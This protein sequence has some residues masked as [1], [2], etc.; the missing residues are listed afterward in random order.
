MTRPSVP[1]LLHPPNLIAKLTPNEPVKCHYTK[2]SLSN[3]LPNHLKVRLSE[4][5]DNVNNVISLVIILHK[6]CVMGNKFY[7]IKEIPTIDLFGRIP[8]ILLYAL[9]S[10]WLKHLKWY[11][12]ITSFF[13]I[14]FCTDSSF[15]YQE[16]KEETKK[17]FC[18]KSCI[19][20]L[21]WLT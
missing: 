8:N 20:C 16:S 21:P 1:N 11:S 19:D 6:G 12:W 7:H 4:I 9:N 5:L 13:Q 14:L 3:S 15:S 18:D 2:N 10:N 17:E